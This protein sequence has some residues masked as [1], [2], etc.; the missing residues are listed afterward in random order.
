MGNNSTKGFSNLEEEVKEKSLFSFIVKLVE[1]SVESDNV[2]LKK[3]KKIDNYKMK[4]KLYPST[5]TLKNDNF[6]LDFSYY[7]ILSW[8]TSKKFFSFKTSEKDSY[9]FLTEGGL[10]A[11]DISRALKGI[12]LDI[13][14]KNKNL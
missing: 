2:E 11:E 5:L 8:Y 4:L 9:K 6:K 7:N 13:S 12:C 3:N 10:E 1:I 14:K